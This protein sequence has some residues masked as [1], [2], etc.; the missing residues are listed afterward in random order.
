MK[1]NKKK[2]LIVVLLVLTALVLLSNSSMPKTQLSIGTCLINQYK[3]EGNIL[4]TCTP[5]NTWGELG[6]SPPWAAPDG[7]TCEKK[8]GI[9]IQLFFVGTAIVIVGIIY[10]FNNRGKTWQNRNN[11]H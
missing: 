6:E 8:D 7:N 4:F 10:F 2:E 1:K 11:K 5:D 9:P 3:C